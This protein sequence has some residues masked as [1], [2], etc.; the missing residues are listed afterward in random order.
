MDEVCDERELVDNLFSD[1]LEGVRGR[2]EN[3][4]KFAPRVDRSC[5]GDED[6]LTS[7]ISCETFGGEREDELLKSFIG[8]RPESPDTTAPSSE[9]G[10]TACGISS[11][12][13]LTH[14]LSLLNSGTPSSLGRGGSTT[15]GGGKSLD[16]IRPTSSMALSTSATKSPMVGL[17]LRWTTGEDSTDKVDGEKAPS[18][19]WLG[20]FVSILVTMGGKLSLAADSGL[21][22][23]TKTD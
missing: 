7:R 17:R 6:G 1:F 9:V 5:R 23:N 14:E 19:T 20:L 22:L 21:D 4:F 15:V 8:P 10:V 18:R 12:V 2:D 16:F 13:R 3:R 11:R